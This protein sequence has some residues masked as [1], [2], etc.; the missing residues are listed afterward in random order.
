[1]LSQ[2]LAFLVK[3]QVP[4]YMITNDQ[5]ETLRETGMSWTRIALTLGIVHDSTLYCRRQELGLH[6]SFVGISYEESY[7]VIM[8]MLTQTPYAGESC[9]SGG[10]GARGIFVQRHQIRE[11]LRTIHPVS[12]V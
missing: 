4:R 1:M 12:R 11:I 3:K 9:V 7:I 8:G 5:I 2:H 10:L 6:E